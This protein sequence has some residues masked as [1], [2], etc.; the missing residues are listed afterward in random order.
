MN[1]DSPSLLLAG[2]FLLATACAQES[3]SVPYEPAPP[4]DVLR[5][6]GLTEGTLVYRV[7]KQGSQV[8][9]ES[10]QTLAHAGP[11]RDAEWVSVDS[12]MSPSAKGSGWQGQLRV[13]T[14]YYAD[15]GITPRRRTRHD[16]RG[17]QERWTLQVTFGPDSVHT[18]NDY[19]GYGGSPARRTRR[20]AAIQGDGV[21]LGLAAH[22]PA[23]GLLIHRLPLA[24]GWSGSFRVGP[25]GD[26]WFRE[27]S[28]R[29]EGE[30]TIEVP[31]GVFDCWRLTMTPPFPPYPYRIWVTK[32][33]QLL[34]KTLLGADGH[35]LERVLVYA[36][37]AHSRSRAERLRRQ[38]GTPGLTR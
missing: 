29:V 2:S 6:D 26:G 34:V 32:D 5:A 28:L 16:V 4:V 20:S 9:Y 23:L 21:P 7:G 15:D 37:T 3:P 38:A 17:G 36:D 14:V 19:R 35:A 33:G 18:V 27:E 31:A 30:E 8:T 24:A 1:L 13:D 12:V 25:F 22:E 10:V 11:D